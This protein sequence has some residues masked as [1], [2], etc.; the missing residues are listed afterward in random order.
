MHWVSLELGYI[1]SP[2]LRLSSESHK[3]LYL[4]RVV[5]GRRSGPGDR[6]LDKE[7][8]AARGSRFQKRERFI[9]CFL[10]F[11]RL[12]AR[13]PTKAQYDSVSDSVRGAIAYVGVLIHVH[14]VPVYIQ[15]AAW[16]DMILS[17]CLLVWLCVCSV[18]CVCGVSARPR[19]WEERRQEHRGGASSEYLCLRCTTGNEKWKWKEGEG[20]NEGGMGCKEH[21]SSRAAAISDGKLIMYSCKFAV[22][23]WVG[24]SDEDWKR[25]RNADWLRERELKYSTHMNVHTNCNLSTDPCLRT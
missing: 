6:L 11:C 1:C 22:L 12:R 20:G 13:G 16:L 4:D 10:S 14:Y 5:G 24:G 17:P 8:E 2:L 9:L 7:P 15:H 18:R 21:L 23:F 25:G 19:R 3:G